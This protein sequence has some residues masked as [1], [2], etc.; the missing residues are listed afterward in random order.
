M[1]R[2]DIYRGSLLPETA[3]TVIERAIARILC[4]AY[5]QRLRQTDGALTTPNL[6]ALALYRRKSIYDYALRYVDAVGE[7]YRF[8]QYETAPDNG[9]T[10]IA[11]FDV[12]TG[13]GRWLREGSAAEQRTSRNICVRNTALQ[14]DKWAAQ[15]TGWAKIVRIWEGDYDDESIA[16]VFSLKPAFVIV[17]YRITREPFSLTPG[18]YYRQ[19]F[20]Y[21]VWGISQ[22]L[23][24]GPAGIL[25]GLAAE[26]GIDPG[27]NYVMGA[28]VR[29]LAGSSLGLLG[30]AS[31]EIGDE[32]IVAHD[33]ANR[34]FCNALDISVCATLHLPDDDILPLTAVTVTSQ[35]SA[36]NDATSVDLANYVADGCN[37]PQLGGLSS[38]IF[39]GYAYIGGVLVRAIPQTITFP[40]SSDCYRD[41]LPSGGF[42]VQSVPTGKEPPALGGK[43]ALRIGVTQTDSSGIVGD[44]FICST[45]FNLVG[46]DR[47]PKE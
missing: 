41:L 43:G 44:R 4:L 19:K 26:T 22:S 1:S 27:L 39:G 9:S 34:V 42:V 6:A 31:T 45:L 17:P 2:Q 7:T 5:Q 29:A 18:S 23:R 46:P 36:K 14:L 30:V 38:Q 28:A 11:P 35:L 32:D 24:K 3:A 20:L 16:E 37:V 21:R 8:D 25:G 12:G 40:A 47:I 10:V 33:L 13:A 15:R